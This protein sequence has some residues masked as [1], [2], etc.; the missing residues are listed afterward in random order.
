MEIVVISLFIAIY[1]IS[2]LFFKY[3][4]FFYVL[5]IP[6]RPLIDVRILNYIAITEL[7]WLIILYYFLHFGIYQEAFQ[8]IKKS[9]SLQPLIIFTII[10]FMV[11][12][13]TNIRETMLANAFMDEQT[14]SLWIIF[15]LL[16]MFVYIINFIA[17]MVVLFPNNSYRQ[18]IVNAMIVSA[19]VIILSMILAPALESIGLNVKEPI[20]YQ[21]QL[22]GRLTGLFGRG[23]VNSISTFLNILFVFY[24][25]RLIILKQPYTLTNIIILATLSVGILYTGS[26]MGFVTFAFV[27]T[28]YLIITHVYQKRILVQT[29]FSIMFAILA[30]AFIAA[31]L[32]QHDRI[33]LVFERIHEQGLLYEVSAEGHRFNRWVGFINFT[34]SDLSRTLW[35]SNE[36]FY[37]FKYGDFRDPHNAFI[38]IFY[39][40]GIFMI[41]LYVWGL[42]LLCISYLKSNLLP[43]FIPL[44]VIVLISMMIISSLGFREY[45]ILSLGILTYDISFNKHEHSSL[46]Y[47]KL[48]S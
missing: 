35:G 27:L 39:Y 16:Q 14:S 29:F 43:H 47:S 15:R 20:E 4:L 48:S 32:Y 23:D 36:I 21:E 44:T 12:F 3:A 42:F 5:F 40:T 2:A 31:I 37:A 17:I 25:S 11:H 6:I 19:V 41:L 9:R 10:I 30:L 13:I 18:L 8:K 24:I 38:K 22:Q 46:T 7:F 28:Y 1:I 34:L 45:Y 33:G 26:R